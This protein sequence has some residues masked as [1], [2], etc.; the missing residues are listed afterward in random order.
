MTNLDDLVARTRSK[1]TGLLAS[2]AATRETALLLAELEDEQVRRRDFDARA[3]ARLDGTRTVSPV[4]NSVLDRPL[5]AGLDRRAGVPR[6]WRPPTADETGRGIAIVYSNANPTFYRAV[7]ER[8][9][10]DENFRIETQHGAFEMSRAQ[11]EA[12]LPAVVRSDSYQRGTD[13]APGA[14]RYV[15]G[16]VPQSIERYRDATWNV[17]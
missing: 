13:A 11:F 7:I 1:L 15:T 12:A 5:P 2:G 17:R 10:A 16:R 3:V 8:L 14:A 4:T 6:S 9:E